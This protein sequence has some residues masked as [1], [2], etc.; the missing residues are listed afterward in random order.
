[1]DLIKIQNV[2]ASNDAESEDNPHNGRKI[3]A[4]HLSDNGVISRRDSELCKTQSCKDN[5]VIK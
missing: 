5:T 2:Y 3:F 1:M 4:Y